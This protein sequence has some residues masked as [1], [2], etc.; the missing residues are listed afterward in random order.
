MTLRFSCTACGRCCHDLRLPLS[1][2][3]ALNWLER[4]G[5]VEI[6]ADAAPVLAEQ[7]DDP[8]VTYRRERALSA[9]SGKLAIAVNLTLAATFSGR[10]LH[11]RSDMR[12]GAYDERPNTCRIYP[13]ELLPGR[14]VVPGTKACP[15]E[16]WSSPG[17][18]LLSREGRPADPGVARAVQQARANG[19]ADVAGKARLARLLGINTSA[20]ENEGLVV[21]RRLKPELLTALETVVSGSIG[22]LEPL[23]WQFVS[24]SS[25]TRRLIEEA[26]AIALSVVELENASF[27]PFG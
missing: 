12:C 16:A 14:L 5:E 10:C 26:G 1:L 21:H 2:R 27:L 20:L 22:P 11:L 23:E 15:P 19:L 9:T 4:G 8:G 7:P 17:P 6:L 25:K 18:T 13:A 24:P 3:E